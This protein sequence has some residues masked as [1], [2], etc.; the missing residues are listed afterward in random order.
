MDFKKSQLY[1]IFMHIYLPAQW[2]GKMTSCEG[3]LHS[4]THVNTRTQRK[5][6]LLSHLFHLA[7]AEETR[8]TPAKA[9]LNHWSKTI[10]YVTRFSNEGTSSENLRLFQ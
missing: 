5:E 6:V 2:T 7:Q 8:K 4:Q 3:S 9:P 1:I 10:N